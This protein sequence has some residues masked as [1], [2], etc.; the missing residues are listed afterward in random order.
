MEESP[1][2]CDGKRTIQTVSS[3]RATHLTDPRI[4]PDE[5]NR[6]R[7]RDCRKVGR[8]RSGQCGWIVRYRYSRPAAS[9]PFKRSDRHNSSCCRCSARA[10]SIAAQTDCLRDAAG[11]DS[12]CVGDSECFGSPDGAGERFV[13]GLRKTSSSFRRKCGHH[14]SGTASTGVGGIAEIVLVSHRYASAAV[15]IAF[16]RTCPDISTANG[17]AS[18][19]HGTGL[20]ATRP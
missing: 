19:P 15:R 2:C 3:R 11:R 10:V 13:R 9:E 1:C 7:V 14:G 5:A 8:A 6:S 16:R 18:L 12:C 4:H 17:F 20:T